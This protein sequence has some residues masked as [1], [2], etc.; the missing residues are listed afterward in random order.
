MDFGFN[1]VKSYIVE[2]GTSA[3]KEK[4]I[5]LAI[6][7]SAMFLI[8]GAAY[9]ADVQ[10]PEATSHQ[11]TVA[12]EV[13]E[14]PAPKPP[15]TTTTTQPPVPELTLE[16]WGYLYMNMET[17]D[18][19]SWNNYVYS[20]ELIHGKCGQWHDLAISVG[21]PESEWPK[22]S[23]IMFRESRCHWSSHNKTD[24]NSGSRGLLQINGY[25]CRKSQFTA[26]GWLQD[27]GILNVCDDLFNPTTN[28]R[29]GLAMWQYGEDKYGCGWRGPWATSCK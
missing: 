6:L 15:I 24:P 16:Q 1:R 12:P 25:W 26:H 8:A 7:L 5:S 14:P 18:P 3:L 9:A 10:S 28:L 4:S 22:L 29:A 13:T 2:H 20:K 19:V 23:K 27:L 11:T 17:Q 21:W